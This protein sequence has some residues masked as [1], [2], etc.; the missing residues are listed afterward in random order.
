M[1][2]HVK[3]TGCFPENWTT[4]LEI[5]KE[6]EE[7]LPLIIFIDRIWK[8]SIFRSLPAGLGTNGLLPKADINKFC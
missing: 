6:Y 7:I 5:Q 2:Q 4:S 1:A 3:I 8:E